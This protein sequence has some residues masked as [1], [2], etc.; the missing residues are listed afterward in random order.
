MVM[1]CVA[2]GVPTYVVRNDNNGNESVFH[3]MRLL[4]WIAADADGDDGMRS[5]PAIM[6]DADGP[7]K[8]DM[9]IECVVSQDLSYGLNLAVFKTMVSPPITR[10]AVKQEHH[11]QG[12][13]RM[14]LAK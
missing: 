3:C 7:V 8:G 9:M 6:L 11:S 10:Q 13:C 4:L 12:W 1:H 2:D 14:E 5:N